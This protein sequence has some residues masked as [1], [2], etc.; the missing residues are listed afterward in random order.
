[1]GGWEGLDI[2]RGITWINYISSLDECVCVCV[3]C[4]CGLCDSV[5]DEEDFPLAG[6]PLCR[7]STVLVSQFKPVGH[8][9]QW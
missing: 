6:T 9:W 4:G 7:S 1:M 8:T 2:R 3:Y 5:M